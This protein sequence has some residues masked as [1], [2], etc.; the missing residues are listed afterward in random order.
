MR[1]RL[2]RFQ[3]FLYC[4]QSWIEFIRFQLFGLSL[5][6][7]EEEK[8]YGK[9]CIVTGSNTGIG[10][11]VA[12][13]LSKR[14]AFV[15]LA[16]RNANAGYEAMKEITEAISEKYCENLALLELDLSD[17]DSVRKF[18]DNFKKRFDKL[19]LLI[20]N[21]GVCSSKKEL[22][23]TKHGF[24]LHMGVNHLGHFLL[25]NL[26]LDHL[27]LA[28]GRVVTLVSTALLFAKLNLDDIMMKN[29]KNPTTI[30]AT[31][32]KA[33]NNSKLANALFTMELVR[34]L[35]GT[36]VTAV[37]VDP[38]V[39]QTDVYRDYKRFA[40]LV[41]NLSLAVCGMSAEMVDA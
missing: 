19:D 7:E 18:V 16:C 33:Y 34:Q 36:G 40:K 6:R 25:T 35:R 41:A 39:V 26:L 38:G 9:V 21:A 3:V 15:I 17:L 1:R 2:S 22:Q 29:V 27:K 37:A 10:K 24:E 32:S 14:G 4:I 20:N 12:L 28:K 5:N 30:S 8:I 31:T 13:E 23:K 11:K